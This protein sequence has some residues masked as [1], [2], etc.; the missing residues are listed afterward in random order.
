M[1]AYAHH[2][3]RQV[4]DSLG[5]TRQGRQYLKLGER[6]GT[7][8]VALVPI[9]EQPNA[10]TGDSRTWYLA[11]KSRAVRTR[12]MLSK[13]PLQAETSSGRDV[14][15]GS[16]AGGWDRGMQQQTYGG[17]IDVWSRG[18]GESTSCDANGPEW[19]TAPLSLVAN[20]WPALR[21]AVPCD[22]WI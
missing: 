1:A 13:P 16:P 11:G 20:D 22:Y 3:P 21:P 18:I 12:R 2:T 9:S 8:A 6:T 10:C 5:R 17:C 19:P 7:K 4:S 15:T 14:C